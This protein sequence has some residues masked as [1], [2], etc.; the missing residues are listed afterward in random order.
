MNLKE[1][2]RLFKLASYRLFIYFAMRAN[3]K[4]FPFFFNF[5]SSFN[6]SNTKVSLKDD[7]YFYINENKWRFFY[8]RGIVNY[9]NGLDCKK[10]DLSSSYLIDQLKFNEGDVI[11]D[12]G[13]HNGD[14]YLCFEKKIKYYGIEPSPISF[15]NL[16]YN[17][18][19]Q[20]LINK[21]IWKSQ[22]KKITFFLKD[23]TSDSSIIQIKNFDKKIEIETTTLD[24]IIDKID[25][26]IKLIKLDTEGAEP[27]ALEGLRKNLH[28]VQYITVDCGPERGI[29]QEFTLPECANYLIKNDFEIIN[30]R[31]GRTVILF[32][33]KKFI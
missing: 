15:S 1:F 8:N 3:K 33:N 7:N 10:K 23:K 30:F 31:G 11:I 24:E 26:P 4:T 32:E 17:V 5:L 16:K 28:K 21:G 13:A 12:V 20:M 27:E 14:F 18:P 29:K 22:N 2:L 6:N 19:N 9:T 25:E